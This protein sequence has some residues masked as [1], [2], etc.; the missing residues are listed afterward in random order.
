MKILVAEDEKTTRILLERKLT[1]WGYE[2]VSAPDG[3][4]AWTILQNENHPRLILLDR[5]VPGM[6]GV[7][8]CRRLKASSTP[9]HYVILLTSLEEKEEVVEGLDAGAD[10]YIVKPF[11]PKELRSRV[12]VGRRMLELQSALS[13]KDRLQGVLEMA[14]AVCHE[15]NQPLQVIL[16]LCEL[17]LVDI[18]KNDLFRANV[19]KIA[20]QVEEMGKI[21]A[22]LMKIASYK[23]K[24]YLKGQIVDI[25]RSSENDS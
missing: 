24:A 18:E 19:T 2:V 1:E 21:T 23:T 22:K 16:G 11:H 13:E 25:D 7:E 10:E 15:M 20:E 8:I 9:Q 3:E 4:K 12:N 17:L 5:L 14:G 6:D